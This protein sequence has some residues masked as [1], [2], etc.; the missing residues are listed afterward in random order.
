[1]VPCGSSRRF[2]AKSNTRAHK[3]GLVVTLE[4]RQVE[5]RARA[6]LDELVRV[7]KQVQ[8]EIE[9]RARAPADRRASRASRSDASRAGARGAP[10]S[11]G[12][13]CSSC[14][15]GRRTRWCGAPHR[16]GSPARRRRFPRSAARESSQ[17]AMN[18]LAPELS[19]LMT[20]LRSVGPV[21]STR[22]S[23]RS[24]G[25]GATRQSDSRISARLGQE[26]R[27]LAGVQPT[28]ALLAGLQQL[29]DP[30]A[31]PLDQG[32]DEFQRLRGQDRLMFGAHR[33]AD[34]ER[35]AHGVWLLRKIVRRARV[36]KKFTQLSVV[37]E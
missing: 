19:A 6:A 22:R 28:L 27:Q 3:R 29:R 33:G 34:R 36:I 4:L 9:Q 31:E 30:G 23:S 21:I 2:S 37:P 24:F 15:P 10:R 1:M 35:G 14:P 18:T 12:S 11:A 8:A 7:V 5:I 25:I 17:S 16:A 20:I 13:A 26:V 32:A